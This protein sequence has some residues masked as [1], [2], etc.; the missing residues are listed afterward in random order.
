MCSVHLSMYVYVSLY[1]PISPPFS[2]NQMIGIR[3]RDQR[4]RCKQIAESRVSFPF[5]ALDYH[6]LIA[7]AAETMADIGSYDGGFESFLAS[8]STSARQ[9][10]RVQLDDAIEE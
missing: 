7:K 8:P 5:L 3:S 2:E 6:A 9:K 10:A 4:L 1:R